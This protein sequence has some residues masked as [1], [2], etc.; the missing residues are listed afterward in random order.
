MLGAGQKYT[1]VQIISILKKAKSG[2][3]VLDIIRKYGISDVSFYKWKSKYSG[4]S[5]S[6]LKRL[7]ETV[8]FFVL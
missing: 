2:A 7:K 3:R 6:E 5:V 4:L 1:E 8:Q